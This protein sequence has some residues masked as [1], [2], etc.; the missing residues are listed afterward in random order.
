VDPVL[1]KGSGLVVVVMGP[2][3]AMFGA[4]AWLAVVGAVGAGVSGPGMGVLVGMPLPVVA[5]GAAVCSGGALLPDIDCPG[6]LSLKDG[7]TVV[8]AFGIVGE[9]VG[10]A[11]NGMALLVFNLTKSRHDTDRHSGHRLL[12]HTAV[13][14]VGLGMLTAFGASLPGTFAAGGKKYS[15]G[16]VVALLI[17]WA[18]LH[19][20]LFGLFEKWTKEQRKKFSL[21]GV[22]VISAVLTMVTALAL[23]AETAGGKFWWLGLAVGGGSAVHCLGDA[24]TRAGVPFVW[25][26][27]IRGRR[28]WEIQLP[29]LLAIRAGG[30]FEY[31]ALFPLLTVLTLWLVV[32]TMPA[33]R[34]LAVSV[35][36]LI[37]IHLPS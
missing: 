33:S 22:M 15:T 25:P 8:R 11:M 16:T 7:S 27:P 13:F 31:A 9:A 18:C 2:T 32:Y 5:M 12:T 34:W 26:I 14:A 37:G 23:P 1:L 29:S 24:I 4:A 28:W 19:L 35:A 6:S 10:A 20:S 21:I 30:R 36:G 3:H 17:M